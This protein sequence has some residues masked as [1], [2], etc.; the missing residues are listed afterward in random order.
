MSHCSVSFEF[1]FYVGKTRFA[2]AIAGNKW[3]NSH[4]FKTKKLNLLTITFL[5]IYWMNRGKFS[6]INESLMIENIILLVRLLTVFEENIVMTVLAKLVSLFFKSVHV[7]FFLT[8]SL[9]DKCQFLTDKMFQRLF[10][11][12]LNHLYNFANENFSVKHFSLICIP[13]ILTTIYSLKNCSIYGRSCRIHS[14]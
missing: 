2:H 11:S 1:C 4:N 13:S 14:P 10:G 9:I 8:R 5:S 6:Y 12:L 7:F 3:A